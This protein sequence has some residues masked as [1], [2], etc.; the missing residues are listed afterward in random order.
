MNLNRLIII[1]FLKLLVGWGLKV[2]V[3]A[4]ENSNPTEGLD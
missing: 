1:L 2:D 4:P 3:A